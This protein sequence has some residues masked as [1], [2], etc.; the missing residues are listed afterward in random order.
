[1]KKIYSALFSMLTTSCLVIIFAVAI[2]YATFVENDYGTET[3]KILVYNAWWFNLLLAFMAFNLVGNLIYYKAFQLK[4]WSMVLFHLSFLIILAGAGIT[5]FFSYE[6]SIHIREGESSNRMISADTFIR[7]QTKQNGNSQ[8]EDW[9][10]QFSPYT[11]NRFNKSIALEGEDVQVKVINYVPSAVEDVVADEGGNPIVSFIVVNRNTSRRDAV[12]ELGQEYNFEGFV[13]SFEGANTDASIYIR[14]DGGR[15]L[16]RAADTLLLVSMTGATEGKIAPAQEF[17]ID[18]RGMYQLGNYIFALKSY[19]PYGR[20]ILATATG[21]VEGMAR[22]ALELQLSRDGE[23]KQLLVFEQEEGA[24]QAAAVTMGNAEISVTYGQKLIELPF[25]IYLDDFQLERYPGSRSPSSFASEV[26]LIDNRRNVKMPYRIYM[27][28]ILDYGGFR[29]FQSSYDNDEK[30]TVLSVSHDFWGTAVTYVGYFLMTLGMIF[31]FFNK[32]SRFHALLR[33]GARLKELKRQTFG[34][35][36]FGFLAATPSLANAADPAG[37]DSRH[38]AS[39]EKLLVQDN[40]GRVEPVNTLASEVLRKLNR[41]NSFQGMSP[42]EVFL[43]MSVRPAAWGNVPIIS[44]SN[45]ELRKQL[46]LTEKLVSFNGMLDPATGAYKI[47]ELVDEV[48]KKAPTERDKFDKEVIAVD[49]RMNICYQIFNGDFLRVFP[50]AGDENNS[51]VNEKNFYS[52]KENRA[53][54]ARL[55]SNYFQA[56]NQAIAQNDYRLAD[57][58]LETL[59]TLQQTFGNDIIPDQSKIQ[60]EILYNRFNVFGWLSKVL[61]VAGF[62]LLIFHLVNIFNEKL[63]LKKFLTAGTVIVAFAFAAYTGGLAIRWY[64]S[65]HAP[66]SNGYETLLYIGWATLLSGFVFLKKSQITLAVTAILAS[67]TLMVAGMSWMNPEITPLVPVLKSY[68]LIIHVAVITASYGFLGVAA[69]LGFLNLLIMIMR[70]TKS[71][72]KAS[73]TI[74]ELSVI[75]EL[76]MITGLILLTVGAFIG[77]VWANES[78]GRYWGWDPKE[79]WALVTILVYSFIIHL[80]KVPGMHSHFATSALALLGFSSVLMTFFGV[81]YYLSGMHSYAQGDAPPVPDFVYV[82][83]AVMLLAVILAAVSES[84]HGGAEKAVKLESNANA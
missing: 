65:G 29:F 17:T 81:N 19:I 83:A 22:N 80:R 53:D 66:W 40:Q 57:Q 4:R 25:Q 9:K 52:L 61:G 28:N 12:L 50:V 31:T 70:T 82:A 23:R 38:V 84:R 71:R 54:T 56:V 36:V 27:N 46:G 41:G 63:K 21:N 62:Y 32:K 74:V 15:L 34:V 37:I 24:E 58:Q 7:V 59:K 47:R 79:T 14:R 45:S 60:L 42:S 20:K 35:L 55:L 5:R 51:W 11:N 48:Y 39:F 30:G 43:G 64:I 3:A 18:P 44:V 75:I 13:L 78:W 69:L 16:A 6:G 67:L 2:A 8:T 68:W 77:G 33:S 72:Q 76:S 49:E 1:M 73:F 26:T 10:V